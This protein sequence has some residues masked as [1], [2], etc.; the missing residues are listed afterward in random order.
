MVEDLRRDTVEA[1]SG[2]GG[3]VQL[4]RWAGARIWS[5]TFPQKPT[6]MGQLVD[7]ERQLPER[8]EIVSALS[9]LIYVNRYRCGDP[10]PHQL[11][12]KATKKRLD[13]RTGK[14][15]V[16]VLEVQL[17][18]GNE[19]RILL[20]QRPLR[21]IF[22]LTEGLLKR[23]DPA[24]TV[25]TVLDVNGHRRRN[26]GIARILHIIMVIHFRV[27]ARL[28]SVKRHHR[29]P[30]FKCKDSPQLPQCGGQIVADGPPVNAHHTGDL[31]NAPIV[32]I[33]QRNGLCLSLAQLP[34]QACE[35]RMAVFFFA[36]KGVRRRLPVDGNPKFFRKSLK[37]FLLACLSS[38]EI[39]NIVGNR[40]VQIASDVPDIRRN[41][42]LHQRKEELLQQLIFLKPITGLKADRAPDKRTV[43]P[44]HR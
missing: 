39:D 33:P 20:G 8:V 9:A 4:C 14:R 31:G 15:I 27:S 17:Q 16:D 43:L 13:I 5:L 38:A 42:A 35:R 32:P 37:M 28:A 7:A 22:Q 34:G 6:E 21:S 1:G 44:K 24:P 25:E 3:T 18:L 30:S 11:R 41:G 23:L 29:Y 26:G 10:E 19:L 12:Q 36:H 40:P 2:N